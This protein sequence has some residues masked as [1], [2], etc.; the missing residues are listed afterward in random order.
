MTSLPIR[1]LIADDHDIVRHGLRLVLS[2][3]DDFEVVAEASNGE[4]A[5]NLASDTVPDVA[6]LDWKMPVMDGFTAAQ[7]IKR[8]ATPTKTLILSGAPIE[9][10]LFERLDTVHGFIH[11]DTN[12]TNLA[13]AIRT[14][15][16]GQRYLGPLIAQALIQHSLN[17]SQPVAAPSLS[18]RE[19]QVLQLMAT[20]VTYREMAAQLMI[21]ES[22]VH[23]YV[24]R[25]LAKLE[26]P[27]RTQA[28][29][30]ALRTGL[31]D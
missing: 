9:T 16:S 2:Q 24:K 20:P 29:L 26:Q 17:V 6:L 25:I 3:I 5:Y 8:H 10:H 12:S 30:A 23:T 27:N 4:D 11:K 31:I 19:L 13:H 1:I 18:Q 22:T 15:A 7:L 21:G 28:V 14:V